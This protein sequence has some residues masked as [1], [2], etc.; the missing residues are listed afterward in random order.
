VNHTQIMT[1]HRLDC[2]E[3]ELKVALAGQA[4]TPRQIDR[5]DAAGDTQWEATLASVM[6]G[7]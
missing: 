6:S 1:M 7:R 2:V 3:K 4:M 5:A